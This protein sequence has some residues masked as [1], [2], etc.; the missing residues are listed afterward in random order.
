MSFDLWTVGLQVVN[1]LVLVWLLERLLYRPVLAVIGRRQKQIEQLQQADQA[2]HDALAA[3]QAR[4]QAARDQVAAE[5]ARA[6]EEA[7]AQARE[8]RARLEEE[9]RDEMSRLLVSGRA[10]L[11]QERSDVVRSLRRKS[12]E[13]G[14]QLAKRLLSATTPGD[15]DEPF[16]QTVCEQLRDMSTAD[17]GRLL[18]GV[19][20]GTV[21]RVVTAQPLAD[22]QQQQCRARICAALGRTVTMTFSDDE[23]LIAGIE[24]FFPGLVLRHC[25]RDALAASEDSLMQAAEDGSLEVAA[26][27]RDAC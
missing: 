4:L 12:V 25:W 21:V 18:A 17:Q 22:V 11:Q 27:G 9:A 24:V 23:G 26:D 13:L 1:F 8:E 10:R 2:A 15:G 5:R 7:H 19:D 20:D 16:V 3:E 6:L 14:V